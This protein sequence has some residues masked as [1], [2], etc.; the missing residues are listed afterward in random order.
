MKRMKSGV[1]NKERKKEVK[2]GKGRKKEKNYK[3]RKKIKYIIF[4]K[5]GKKKIKINPH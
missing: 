3:R 4:L 2:E 5:I 1:R